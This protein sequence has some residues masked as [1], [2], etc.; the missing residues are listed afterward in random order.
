VELAEFDLDPELRD[1]GGIVRGVASS[2]KDPA[3]TSEDILEIALGERPRQAFHGHAPTRSFPGGPQRLVELGTRQLRLIADTIFIADSHAATYLGLACR[4]GSSMFPILAHRSAFLTGE[5]VFR[6][7]VADTSQTAKLLVEFNVQQAGRIQTAGDEY[8]K[9]SQKVFTNP[10]SQVLPQAY[11]TLAEGILRPLGSLTVCLEHIARGEATTFQNFK[12]LGQLE[13]AL[14]QASGRLAT[15]AEMGMSRELRNFDAH[16]DIVRTDTGAL[17]AVDS[18]GR[19]QTIDIDD[20][21]ERM[22]VLHSFLDGVDVAI[23]VAFAALA[24]PT[25][26]FPQDFRPT[27]ALLQSIARLAAAELTD[28]MVE[29]MT[30]RTGVGIVEFSGASTPVQLRLLVAAIRRQSAALGRIEIRSTDGVLLLD[31]KPHDE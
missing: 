10:D 12:T 8:Q 30:I 17:A 19:L 15:L 31:D 11:R 25:Q 29:R 6:A 1:F 18:E 28:G 20:L 22:L 13:T 2:P 16:E 4:L 14:K 26:V 23:S 7:A 9:L 24:V 21:C 27:E 3:V 5:L